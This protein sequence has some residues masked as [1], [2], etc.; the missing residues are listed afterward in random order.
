MKKHLRFLMCWQAIFS[1]IIISVSGNALANNGR[2]GIPKVLAQLELVSSQLSQ[3]QSQLDF[4]QQ[5]LTELQQ[6]TIDCTPQRYIDGLCGAGN[7]PFDLVVSICGNLGGEV[8]IGGQYALSSATSVEAGVGWADGPDVSLAIGASMPVVVFPVPYVP[9]V[10]PSEV[11]VGA[12]GSIGLGMDT[13]FEGIKIPIGKDI[14]RNRV[15]ALLNKLEMGAGQIQSTLLDAIDKTF[16]SNAVATALVAKDSFA[17]LEFSDKD[18]LALFTSPEVSQL[19]SLI[20]VGDNM[21]TLLTDPGSM[22]PELNPLKPDGLCTSIDATS[23]LGGKIEKICTFV[24]GLPS[25]KLVM[26]AFKT[27]K[28]VKDIVVDIPVKV[29]NTICAVLPDAIC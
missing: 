23:V 11:S 29:K 18:P 2:G 4:Q 5:Q 7:S 21:T 20:P 26:G 24:N 17:S 25:D 13:C 14:D 8:A 19:V 6:E 22:V 15:I 27:I 1:I 3:V 16:N 12:G 28:D 10:L 9:V